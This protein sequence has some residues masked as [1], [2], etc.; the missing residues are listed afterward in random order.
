M[1]DF[2]LEPCPFC[3]PHPACDE[4]PPSITQEIVGSNSW[5]VHAPCCDFYGP[6]FGTKAEA[7]KAWNRRGMVTPMDD[8]QAIELFEGILASDPQA[9]LAGSTVYQVT[10][11]E[12][13]KYVAELAP[14]HAME[15][16]ARL[17]RRLK[18]EREGVED[19]KAQTNK[20]VIALEDELEAQTKSSTRWE[21]RYEQQKGCARNFKSQRDQLKE[22]SELTQEFMRGLLDNLN[23]LDD[24][25]MGKMDRGSV[26]ALRA[27]VSEFISKI[28]AH[29]RYYSSTKS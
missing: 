10:K 24:A 23:G 21:N 3:Y 9:F 28:K 29:E 22:D 5:C 25:D 17:Q 27:E 15:A 26:I 8:Q 12:L 14:K 4:Y 7:A 6:L 18:A 11:D 13:L 2:A 20:A 16:V 1:T 19:Y